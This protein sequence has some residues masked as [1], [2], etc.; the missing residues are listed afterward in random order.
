MG[1]PKPLKL[2][3]EVVVTPD[4][5]PFE[6]KPLNLATS[7]TGVCP[8]ADPAAARDMGDAIVNAPKEELDTEEITTKV[9]DDRLYVNWT[10]SGDMRASAAAVG[11]FLEAEG[12]RN[13]Y[14]Q[15]E[16]GKD[17]TLPPG[18]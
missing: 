14:F 10:P 8:A 7:I 9:L 18:R 13:G 6:A 17:M 11:K 3:T 15:L 5:L 16:S 12:C 2:T 4:V 1:A